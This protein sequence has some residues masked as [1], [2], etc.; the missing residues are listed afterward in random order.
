MKQVDRESNWKNLLIDIRELYDRL[1][2]L[3]KQFQN[4]GDIKYVV[5]DDV[6]N[7][8]HLRDIVCEFPS[9]LVD[10]IGDNWDIRDI[11]G[12]ETKMRSNWLSSIDIPNYTYELLQEF[13]SGEFVTFI[14]EL[15]GEKGLI[16]DI[17][18]KGGGLNSI[19]RGGILAP[20]YDGS[21][22]GQTGLYRR[23]NFI[24]YL[25]ENWRPEYG[26]QLEFFDKDFKVTKLIEPIFNRLLLFVTN[27]DSVHG[28]TKPVICPEGMSRKSLIGYYYTIDNR[29]NKDKNREK[30]GAVYFGDLI[31]NG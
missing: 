3:Q 29:F 4:S 21:G 12:K 27:E 28:M 6:I 25:N 14:E 31:E 5:I 30:H 10:A 8:I 19:E 7:P 23:I 22:L 13:N 24:L 26:G 20:H 16:P 1:P 17:H 9:S 18:Y 15:T 2:E 11:P